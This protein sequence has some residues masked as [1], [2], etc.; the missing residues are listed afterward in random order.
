MVIRLA[1]ES[2]TPEIIKVLKSSLGETSSK[3]TI[4]VWNYKHLKNPF[5][6]SLVLVAVE[7]NKIVGVRAF[8]R[9]Q[10]N[11][12][13]G[14]SFSAFRAV[15]T[16]THP[17]YQGKGIFKKLTLEALNVAKSLQGDFVFNTPNEMS[18]PGYLK[19]GWSEVSKIEV[20]LSIHLS[21]NILGSSKSSYTLDG[22]KVDELDN[23]CSHWNLNMEKGKMFTPKSKE[24]LLWR[25]FNN[26]IQE[27]IIS[28]TNKFF[29][30]G[31][32]KNRKNF[33]ELRISEIIYTNS[34][35]L[36]AIK[37]IIKSWASL[38]GAAVISYTTPNDIK[39]FKMDIKGKFGPTLTAKNISGKRDQ[40]ILLDLQYWNY[41]LGDLELF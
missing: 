26:P 11:V 19:F 41:A 25:Y 5:G 33:K 40:N 18:K 39:L 38:H 7:S 37:K 23:L 8:M 35:D 34:E 22:G 17:D 36:K 24:Y 13:N 4:D 14:K 2:D 9:W 31:Y 16:A 29:I 10:W 27:Y 21:R 20:R 28:F 12:N 30:S 1:T 3:K 32:I 6:A 15:D